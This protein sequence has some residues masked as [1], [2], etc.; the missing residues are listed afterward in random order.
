MFR[1]IW[2]RLRPAIFWSYGRGSWQ[3][4]VIV[5]MILGFIFLT[6]KSLF[7]DRPSEEV[8]HEVAAFGE[9]V[10]VFW[11]EPSVLESLRAKGPERRLQELL[12]EHSG[13]VLQILRTESATDEAGNIRGYLVYAQR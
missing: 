8:V 1:R 6:P 7:N 13:E 10:R 5:V 3:Y 2:A 9:D 12:R 11:C 4:D